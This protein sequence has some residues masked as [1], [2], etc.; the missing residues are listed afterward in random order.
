MA[1]ITRAQQ[2]NVSTEYVMGVGGFALES[3][4]DQVDQQLGTGGKKEED[5]CGH[6]HGGECNDPSHDHS[7]SHGGAAAEASCDKGTECTDPSHDHSHGHAHSHGDAEASSSCGHEHG[8][9]CNDPTHDH[10]HGGHMHDDSVS[11]VSLVYDG[12][13]DLDKVN[14]WLGL[15]LEVHQDNIYRM[16]GVLAIE[17]AEERFVFQGVHALFEGSPERP[18]GE[19]EE[20][21]SRMVFIGKDLPKDGIRESFK[22]CL[23][24]QGGATAA[25]ESA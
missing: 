13:V 1:S 14:L 7:H 9:E 2:S 19:G 11:S 10:S 12:N 15:L 6:D 25:V 20:R 17:G 23:V 21:V 22:E 8:A 16:K 5:S 3:V 24:A 18:W 4:V